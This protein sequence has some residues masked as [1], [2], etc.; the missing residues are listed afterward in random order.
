MKASGMISNK[1]IE[2]RSFSP[3]SS[4]TN[5][6]TWIKKVVF[7]PTKDGSGQIIINRDRPS[8]GGPPF[9]APG[10]SIANIQM[11]N[12]DDAC[13]ISQ[14]M[15]HDPGVPL[16]QILKNLGGDTGHERFCQRQGACCPGTYS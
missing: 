15:F 11:G 14:K 5:R 8:K 1:L 9:T 10:G 16:A 3:A 2:D 7:R 13:G 6:I 4:H 12:Q